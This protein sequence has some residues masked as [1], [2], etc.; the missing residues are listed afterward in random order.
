M[1]I[2]FVA[3]RF[4]GFE[5]EI[6]RVFDLRC[7]NYISYSENVD[8]KNSLAN[9]IVQKMPS[10]IHDFFLN[11]YISKKFKYDPGVDCF[12][13]IRGERWTRD[14]LTKVR[15]LY[16][17]AK[18]ILYQ[19]DSSLN[20]PNFSDQINFF[21]DVFTFDYS[22][23]VKYGLEFNPLFFKFDYLS[24]RD[25]DVDVIHKF[26]F[27]GSDYSDRGRLVDSF[28]KVN[29][30]DANDAFV[31]LYRS[32]LSYFY[33]KFFKFGGN[34]DS[35]HDYIRSKPLSDFETILAMKSSEFILDINPPGQVG[36]SART[37]EALALGKKIVT[38]NHNIVDYDFYNENNIFLIDRENL[39]VSEDFLKSKYYTYDDDLLKKYSA[40]TWVDSVLGSI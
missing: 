22:D 26:S 13:I 14:V 1:K 19:W 4:F 11:Y 5:K 8:L 31:H 24:S 6:E 23:A 27:I 33:N 9:I 2:V 39:K 32:R 16:P 7:Y 12:F 10:K 38:T 25:D 29:G 34:L 20:L 40:E 37:F 28:I 15:V 3:P 35:D 30:F 18:L 36:L 21:D 17:K